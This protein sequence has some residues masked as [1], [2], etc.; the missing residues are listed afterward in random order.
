MNMALSVLTVIALTFWP[1]AAPANQGHA[2]AHGQ[3]AV[4]GTIAKVEGDRLMVADPTA[5][6]SPS[7]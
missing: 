2:H 7:A 6:L 1:L 3:D 4:L 5:N